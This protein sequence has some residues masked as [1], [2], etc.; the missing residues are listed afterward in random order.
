M[1]ATVAL[2]A[3]GLAALAVIAGVFGLVIGSF[4]NVV[5]ARVPEG[6]SVVSPP[7][8]CPR[9]GTPIR[10]RD[11]IPVLSWLV[12]RAKCRSCGQ[13]ISW[14]YPAVE[15]LTAACFVALAL[16]FGASL[17]LPAE[18]ALTAG[19][20]ALGLI[21]AD[22]M[23]LPKK[24]V[25]PTAAVLVALLLVAA[26]VGGQWHRLGVA[27][28]SAAVSGAVFLLIHLAVPRGMG[29]G[30][31]R[32]SPVIGLG[33]GWVGWEWAFVGFFLA[34]LIG[35]VVGIALIAAGRHQ[36]RQPIPFGVFL[37]V[38]AFVALLVP[39]LPSLR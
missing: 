28:I 31:V 35:A 38:G 8:A 23:R 34:N 36:R 11:N 39:H 13:P 12:L 10:P 6:R 7:S 32:L 5:V 21:D 26:G 17:T 25:W 30:D 24:V 18:A 20:V 14:R 4:L 3:G 22:T 16:R 1:T 37:A 33:L 15:A 9:C 19:L 27:A 29:F 2:T